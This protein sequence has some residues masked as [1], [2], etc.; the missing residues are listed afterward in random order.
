MFKTQIMIIILLLSVS[1]NINPV[2]PLS[3]KTFFTDSDLVKLENNEIISRMY[4]KYNARKENSDDYIRIPRTIYNDEDFDIYEIKSD[5]KCFMPYK[6]AEDSKLKFYNTL[7]A[8]SKLTGMKYYSR[9]AGKVEKLIVECYRV[10]SLADKEY[11][12]N[13]YDKIYPKVVNLFMQKDNKFGKLIYRSELFNEGN[14]FV[15]VNTCM[16]PISKLIFNIN[17]KEEYKIISFFIYD[18]QKQGFYIYSFQ[19]MR[20]NADALL[21]TGQ[22]SPT[23]FSNR[24]RASTVHLAKLFGLDW[25][26]K[27]NPWPGKYDKY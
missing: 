6:L 16:E 27:L 8:F 18:E 5:E 9:R 15:L 14:N 10:K 7:T 25:G 21:K 20:V 23:T 11:D 1:L 24:L 2:E 17:N 4:V 19:V 13:T 12:D 3:I 26:G 22:I